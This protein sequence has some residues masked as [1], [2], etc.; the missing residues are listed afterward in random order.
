MA[1]LT[2]ASIAGDLVRKLGYASL[3]VAPASAPDDIAKALNWALQTMWQAGED[4][5]LRETL[6]VAL[7]AGVSLYS[8]PDEVRSV[9]GPV[10]LAGGAPLRRLESRGEVSDYALLYLGQSSRALAAATPQAF[11]VEHGRQSGDDAHAVRLHIVPPP[12]VLAVAGHSPLAVEGVSECPAYTADDLEEEDAVP[13]P[14]QF[15]E[16]ILLPL[17]RLAVTRSELFSRPDALPRIEADA[18]RA[19]AALGLGSPV[20]DETRAKEGRPA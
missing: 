7:T 8:L 16:S 10:R 2:L 20:A 11:Y 5:F 19:L 6:S 4:W 12:S 18:E 13:V 15:T 9:L 1:A 14:D 17:A 3:S